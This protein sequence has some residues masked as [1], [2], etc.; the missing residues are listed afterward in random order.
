M[1]VSNIFEEVNLVF[2]REQSSGDRMDRRIAPPFIIEAS[3]LVEVIEKV[4]IR[5]GPPEVEI[6]DLKV[7]PDYVSGFNKDSQ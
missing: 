6:A 4:D 3:L 5:L 1:S 2:G 7:G